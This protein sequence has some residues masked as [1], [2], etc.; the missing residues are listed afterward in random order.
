MAISN[1][2]AK[3]KPPED[4]ITAAKDD[5]PPAAPAP[6]P[7]PARTKADKDTKK[8]AKKAATK[9]VAKNRKVPIT[10]TIDRT[11]LSKIDEARGRQGQSRAAFIAMGMFYVVDRGIFKD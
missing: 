10:L 5:S 11:L 1:P 4:F 3:K 9:P 6:A 8:A 2:H 7:A